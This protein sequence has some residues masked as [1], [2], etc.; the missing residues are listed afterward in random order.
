MYKVMPTFSTFLRGL[1]SCTACVNYMQ[2]HNIEDRIK[3]RARNKSF[4]FIKFQLHGV[5]LYTNEYNI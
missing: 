4:L 1:Y 5:W 3:V 2:K